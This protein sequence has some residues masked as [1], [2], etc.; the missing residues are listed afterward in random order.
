ML[1]AACVIQLKN[2][3]LAGTSVRHN[4]ITRPGALARAESYAIRNK[5][6]TEDDLE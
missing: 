2:S 5:E 3:T 6:G 4:L 1:D